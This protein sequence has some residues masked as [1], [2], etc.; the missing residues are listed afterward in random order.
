MRFSSKHANLSILVIAKLSVDHGPH[1]LTA[2]PIVLKAFG[3][4]KLEMSLTL[5]V[6]SW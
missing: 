4:A 1:M 3:L 2:K 5:I 6:S